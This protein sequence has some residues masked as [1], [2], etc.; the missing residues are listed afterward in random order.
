MDKA[1]LKTRFQRH[2]LLHYAAQNW[3]N[4]VRGPPEQSCRDSILEFLN[5]K[6]LTAC[7]SQATN[8]DP[9][10]PRSRGFPS[11][12]PSLVNASLFGLS[13]TVAFLICSGNDVE[14]T[15]DSG[16]SPLI[17][18]AK[19]GQGTVIRQLL[20]AGAQIEART[21]Y[22]STALIEAAQYGH[23]QTVKLLLEEGADLEAT[24][25]GGC[26][27]LH[28]ASRNGHNAVIDVL[29]SHGA[30][31]EREDLD[32]R[33]ALSLAVFRGHTAAAELLI[34]AASMNGKDAG[35]DEAFYHAIPYS[36]VDLIKLLIDKGAS[37]IDKI[38]DI[39][40]TRLHVAALFGKLEVVKLL[41][42]YRLS[43]MIRNSYDSTPLHE[44]SI[45]GRTEVV[46]LLLEKGA[47]ID[48]QTRTGHT[49]IYW[50]IEG[51]KRSEA[52][53]EKAKEVVTLLLKGGAD[54]NKRSS[55]G[56]TVLH[57]SARNGLSAITEIL[58]ESGADLEA[59]DHMNWTAL[60]VAAA[61]NEKAVV[62]RL[63]AYQAR[64][65]DS[66][67][68]VL[69]T[70]AQLRIAATQGDQD[71]VQ[72]L[73]KRGTVFVPDANGRSA[74]H[75]AAYHGHNKIVEMLLETEMD[76]NATTLCPLKS[77]GLL[78][79]SKGITA[80]HFAASQGHAET[81]SILIRR[82]AHINARTWHGDTPLSLAAEFGHLKCVE[83]LLEHKAN[84]IVADDRHNP[85]PLLKAASRGHTAI[86]R[87]LLANGADI[88][89]QSDTG[90]Q[91]LTIAIHRLYLDIVR[92]LQEH[93][94]KLNII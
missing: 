62:E 78:D 59:K 36:G 12:I 85:T 72:Q 43:P 51:A 4:H 79:S 8:L 15:D 54:V 81:M 83:L 33:R 47:E 70:G 89:A 75:E 14:E 49:P 24:D 21:L 63:L 1:S 90:S 29:L 9:N 88:E 44:A 5:N 19:C 31:V 38:E 7:A 18:A 66:F 27:A 60:Q 22:K 50:A 34:E 35:L 17:A 55:N 23:Q 40:G 52:C 45:N 73:L 48:A 11:V 16:V 10:L 94:F 71:A 61:C 76:I 28:N 3:G 64:R 6:C 67:P 91:I 84:V 13:E 68:E 56:E 57:L 32:N 30:N 37:L 74:L 42:D 25:L 39:H 87:L 20:A 77:Q 80:L 2:P 26:T 86:V 65:E 58:L 41:I 92:L 46:E 53:E 93:G 69:L 82:N